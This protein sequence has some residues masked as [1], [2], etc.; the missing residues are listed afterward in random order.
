MQPGPDSIYLGILQPKGFPPLPDN[1]V[2]E[3]DTVV[4]RDGTKLFAVLH[5]VREEEWKS[6]RAL[7]VFHGLGEHG[8]RYLHVPHYLKQVVDAVFCIDYRGH[9]RSEGLRGHVEDF[10]VFIDETISSVM[11]LDQ[12]LKARFGRSEIHLFAH[13]MGGLIALHSLS[14]DPGLPIHSATLSAPLLKIKVP[15][16]LTKRVAAGVLSKMWGSLQLQSEL[17]PST[18]THDREAVIAYRQDR[19]VHRKLTPRFYSEMNG[20]MEKAR[21]IRKG[22][23]PPLQL[24]VP[25]R[26]AVVDSDEVQDFFKKLHHSQK[27]IKTYPEFYH[28]VCNEVGR[29]KAFEDIAKWI[30]MH[31]VPN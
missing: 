20:W 30:A 29:E 27:E 17:D 2:S 14:H 10:G 5:H 28:E 6:P 22:I 24:L 26:D 3:T 12:K 19:L 16:P 31:N 25:L 4:A 1:W 13:S 8:G 7:I 15:V 23:K 21:K 18:L 11:A 9:G